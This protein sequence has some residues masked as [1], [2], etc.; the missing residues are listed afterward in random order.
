[1]TTLQPLSREATG[2]VITTQISFLLLLVRFNFVWTIKTRELN[3]CYQIQQLLS[4]QQCVELSVKEYFVGSAKKVT[5]YY[6][7]QRILFVGKMTS[8]SMELFFLFSLNFYQCLFSSQLS[9]FLMWVFH[10]VLEMASY[11][12]VKQYLYYQWITL[13]LLNIWHQNTYR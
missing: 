9:W 2:L 10:L 12:T 1:M 4:I 3:T 7:T 11:S 5:Q 13:Q 6:T 8:A